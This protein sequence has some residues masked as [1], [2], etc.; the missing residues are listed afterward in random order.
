MPNGSSSN[1]SLGDSAKARAIPTRWR[2]PF[3]IAAAELVERVRKTNALQIIVD[4]L[5]A[6][7]AFGMRVDPV[8]TESDVFARGK[9]GKQRWR[10]EHHRAIGTGGGYLTAVKDDA[11]ERNLV[12]PGRHRQYGGLAATGMANDRR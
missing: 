3:D 4:D 10:L 11:A 12:Q 2:M 7:L 9:P 8:D 6:L 5:V 1:S